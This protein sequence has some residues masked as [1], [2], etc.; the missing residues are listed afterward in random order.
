LH[1]WSSSLRPL[2]SLPCDLFVVLL[3]LRGALWGQLACRF[4]RCAVPFC[5]SPTRRGLVAV[6]AGCCRHGAYVHETVHEIVL[7]AGNAHSDG[8]S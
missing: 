4:L 5:V 8:R 3:L 6:P 2:A 7:E 1:R